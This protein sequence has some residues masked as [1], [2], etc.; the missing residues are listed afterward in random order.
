[1][2]IKEL[3][4]TNLEK[5]AEENCWKGQVQL[6]RKRFPTSILIF[7]QD[8]KYAAI[9]AHCPHEGYDLEGC[10]LDE[11]GRVTCPLH[12]RH[13]HVFGPQEG[14]FMVRREADTEF[15][16][17]PEQ[18]A[19][20]LAAISPEQAQNAQ[21]IL[22]KQELETL[23][24]AHQMQ[25][26][27]FLEVTENMSIML[28]EVEEQRNALKAANVEQAT[29]NDFVRRVTDSMDD[30]L[31]VLDNQGYIQRI[32]HQ[33]DQDLGYGETQLRGQCLD[34]LLPDDE[35]YRL[36]NTIQERRLSSESV[37]FSALLERGSYEGEHRL[38]PRKA[39]DGELVYLLRGTLLFSP[40]GK[41]EGAVVLA[42][43]ITDL[44]IREEAVR[45]SE[46]TFRLTTE[47]AQD[48]IVM[49]DSEDHIYFWNQAA[50]R[51]F[52]YSEEEIK[53]QCLHDLLVPQRYRAAFQQGF[54]RF[55]NTGDGDVIRQIRE[56]TALNKKGKEF[57]VEISVSAVQVK[58]RWHAIGVLRDISAR[59][60]VEESLREAKEMA[61][62]ANQT[63]SAFLANMSHEIRTP[64]NAIMGMTE[65][66]LNTDL[67]EKQRNYLE[68]VH[69]SAHN[70][71]QIINDILDLSKIEAGKL[72]IEK[73]AFNLEEVFDNLINMVGFRAEEKGLEFILN[74]QSNVPVHLLGDPLRLGQVLI[75]LC[76]NAVKFTEIGEIMLSTRLLETEG[77]C[78]R[79]EFSIHDTGIGLTENQR[80]ALFQAFSQADIS[81]TRKYGG[82]GLG[83]TICKR[84]VELMD[85]KIWVDSVY[86]EGSVF[87]FHALFELGE[88]SQPDFHLPNIQ[89]KEKRIL[90]VD[91]NQA[92]REALVHII[93]S[94]AFSATCVGSGMGALRE[95]EE[96]DLLHPYDL[97]LLDWKM[98]GMDGLET[99]KLIKQNGRLEHVPLVIMVTAY[100]REEIMQRAQRVGIDNF[101]I[102]PVNTSV[103]FDTLIDTLG[104]HQVY[105]TTTST[106]A[107]AAHHSDSIDLSRIRGAHLLVAEDNPINQEVISELLVQ[108]G[109]RV[110][111]VNNGKEALEAV[112][113]EQFDG[114]LMDIQMPEM[115]GYEATRRIR[116][117]PR[118]HDLPIIAMTANAMS[119]DKE[120]SL[121]AGMNDHA[122]KPINQHLLFATLLHWI[123]PK[124]SQQ[125]VDSSDEE[126]AV[127]AVVSRATPVPTNLRS[128]ATKAVDLPDDLPG[129]DMKT[130]LA[131]F[132]GNRQLYG[133]CLIS[134]FFD[135]NDVGHKVKKLIAQ[136]EWSSAEQV[137]H[138][139]K[140][141]SGNLGA[142]ALFLSVQELR[143][144]LDLR[145]L[146]LVKKASDEFERQLEVLLNGLGALVQPQL[147]TVAVSKES[148]GVDPVVVRDYLQTLSSALKDCLYIDESVLA[149]GRS[150]FSSPSSQELFT[151]LEYALVHYEHGQALQ[152]AEMLLNQLPADC[153]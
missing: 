9:R 127:G 43:N 51:M 123:T 82:T 74:T 131:R 12:G 47:A 40:Q 44:K 14:G 81:T 56:V 2:N 141:V 37:V 38:L 15:W 24:H 89:L 137:L 55:R 57:P 50:S 98:P 13:V 101:L 148:A 110:S 59:K 149:E 138:T 10:P 63:K 96:T 83:L 129:L 111:L 52:G 107:D 3:Q 1:M 18:Q 130:A 126:N 70:L 94:F 22:L 80:A 146:P 17:S 11:Y 65:L 99:C 120:K 103:L 19:P 142:D 23:R 45:S 97:V 36:Q 150:Y 152:Y 87:R 102:K 93:E 25:E 147:A 34:I 39:Q 4:V 109:F 41:R 135:F 54:K 77:N 46:E 62:V 151:E 100:G 58:G 112:Q 132:S 145:D 144:A 121:Q 92:A 30:L 125:A 143:N 28:R 78:V 90:V 114:V 124:S 75:N 79:L 32:N 153:K 85:G 61:E 95:L 21:I 139:L 113:R 27:Q 91:D 60:Q 104:R 20:V 68:K 128:T 26:Q 8:G 49:I 6:P 64:M 72:Q 84:L 33:V 76:S 140:G 118:F 5:L 66:A 73:A 69:L 108:S 16:L 53:G 116:K 86:G 134:F 133:Q 117:L 105:G 122:S 31:W 35:L 119:G 106:K 42:T 48:A 7:E 67:S 136:H 71:L 115:D 88:R 29:L